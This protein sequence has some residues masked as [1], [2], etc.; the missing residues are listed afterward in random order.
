MASDTPVKSMPTAE[1]YAAVRA[2]KDLER[3][4][5]RAQQRVKAAVAAERA[6]GGNFNGG[7]PSR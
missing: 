3:F 5:E 7:R 2:L 4:G 1:D 6:R